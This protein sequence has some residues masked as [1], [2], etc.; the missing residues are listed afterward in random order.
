VTRRTGG[1]QLPIAAPALDI[2]GSIVMLIIAIPVVLWAGAKVFRMGLLMYGK[3][4]S[5]A[6][7]VRAL[8]EA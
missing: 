7:V 4:P 8:R 5:L 6:Q 3:R 1:A 2:V